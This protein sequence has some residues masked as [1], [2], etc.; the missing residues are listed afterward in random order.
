MRVLVPLRGALVLLGLAGCLPWDALVA[1]RGAPEGAGCARSWEC[2]D[3]L[4]C[5][6]GRCLLPGSPE[7]TVLDA[8]ANG[9]T[10]A[11]PQ[12]TCHLACGD[13]APAPTAVP[14]CAS[15]RWQCPDG[16]LVE[17]C[18]TET[19]WGPPAPGQVCT[20]GTWS[21]EYGSAGDAGCFT[22]GACSEADGGVPVVP[23]CVYA[24][25]CPGSEAQC[26]ATWCE[27]GE[28]FAAACIAARWQC[29]EGVAEERCSSACQGTAPSCHPACGDPMVLGVAGCAAGGWTCVPGV[30]RTACPPG[31]CWGTPPAG[32][33]GCLD[34]G[35]VCPGGAA[36]GGGCFTDGGCT[37][38]GTAPACFTDP[39]CQSPA[40]P[41]LCVDYAWSCGVDTS[42]TACAAR[43]FCPRDAGHPPPADGGP[44]DASDGGPPGDAS[45]PDAA[46]V[47]A[48]GTDAAV[49]SDAGPPDGAVPA[50]DAGAADASVTDGGADGGSGLPV[51]GPTPA[52]G[53]DLLE[54]NNRA[55]DVVVSLPG[56]FGALPGNGL[57]TCEG[58]YDLFLF[59]APAAGTL[60]ATA[61]CAVGE[62][63]S[64]ALF[65]S[66][67]LRLADG[68]P[69]GAAGGLDTTRA[70]V[71][72]L[73]GDTYYALVTS[74]QVTGVEYSLRVEFP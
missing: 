72:V 63:V 54:P 49:P 28:L 4:R 50:D 73:P 44:A 20:G 41:A 40:L 68:V 55:T 24:A 57:R 59:Q 53:V 38:A 23:G 37:D 66:G 3:G 48:G 27:Q 22:P 56:V 35:W 65:S 14:A 19:C 31:T 33:A 34:G 8:S 43:P 39:C 51:G 36:P 2:A 45:A 10:C 16:V 52:C 26:L 30:A 5:A 71:A 58:D 13:Y 74:T 6:C 9:G 7:C 18:P 32:S 70:E 29:A 64:V 17:D 11:P 42:D 1:A 67:G 61:S 47:D 60:V 69:A 12:P 62:V 21:C 46:P 25:S 15:G